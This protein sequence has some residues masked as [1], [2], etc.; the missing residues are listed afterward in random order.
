MDSQTIK[1][2]EMMY[3]KKIDIKL[4]NFLKPSHT[5]AAILDAILKKLKYKLIDQ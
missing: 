4:K 3:H 1:L 5:L 2:V